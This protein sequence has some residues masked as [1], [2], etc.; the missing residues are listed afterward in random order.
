MAAGEWIGRVSVV[1][2]IIITAA[3]IAYTGPGRAVELLSGLRAEFL[4]LA[5]ALALASLA[6]KSAKWL[7]LTRGSWRDGMEYMASYI[8]VFLPTPMLDAVRLGIFRKYGKDV[9]ATLPLIMWER[10]TDLAAMTIL[11]VSG[12]SFFLNPYSSLAITSALF[13]A[14][15]VFLYL[16]FYNRRFQRMAVSKT[17]RIVGRDALER[18]FS[19]GR[20]ELW[21][22]IVST[23][24]SIAFWTV[25]ISVLQIVFSN[26][27]LPI[28]FHKTLSLFALSMVVSTFIPLPAGV[29][30]MEGVFM[31]F[32]GIGKHYSVVSVMVFRLITFGIQF[33]LSSVSIAVMDRIYRASRA[34][35]R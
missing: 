20:I 8:S 24:L 32:A 29:G 22:I 16:L 6:I 27:S 31:A 28:P 19:A 5:T 33:L 1:A 14:F 9:S 3:L 34:L 7:V 26:Y 17:G 13:L 10:F 23:L 35:K 25:N 18:M 4:A 11:L 15:A 12:L 21:Q 2:S 30:S